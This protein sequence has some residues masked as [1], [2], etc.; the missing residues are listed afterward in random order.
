MA[1]RAGPPPPDVLSQIPR[2]PNLRD[3]AAFQ[4]AR[5]QSLPNL[6]APFQNVETHDK[7]VSFFCFCFCFKD[8]C[9]FF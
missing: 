2:I 8:V 3:L 4:P 1:A 9:D 6:P 5:P 7:Y